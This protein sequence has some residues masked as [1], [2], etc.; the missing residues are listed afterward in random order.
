MDRDSAIE[1]IRELHNSLDRG[2]VYNTS[3]RNL[4]YYYIVDMGKAEYFRQMFQML[5]ATNRIMQA[6]LIAAE[7]YK[8]KFT[9]C[10][11]WSAPNPLNNQGQERKLLLIF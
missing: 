2:E 8:K 6:A 10:E 11:L 9:I 4:V 5:V 7:Y 1:N 3:A